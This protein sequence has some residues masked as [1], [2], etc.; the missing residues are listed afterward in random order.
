MN[1]E[2]IEVVVVSMGDYSW[3]ILTEKKFYAYEKGSIPMELTL[4]ILKR[5]N[6]PRE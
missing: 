6:S 4:D 3:K 5:H 2:D 1:K